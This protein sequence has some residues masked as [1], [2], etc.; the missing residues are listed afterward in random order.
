[1]TVAP[2]P[3]GLLSFL[4]MWPTGQSRPLVSTL[5]D[6][7]GIVLANAAIVPAGQ[8]G[9]LDVYVTDRTHVIIDI[10]GYFSVQ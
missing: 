5:N 7:G 8:G 3:A 2:A 6:F 4:T 10:N 9:S 1:V